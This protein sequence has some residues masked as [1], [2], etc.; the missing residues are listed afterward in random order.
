MSTHFVSTSGHSF[1]QSL[2]QKQTS[3]TLHCGEM[4]LSTK[5]EGNLCDRGLIPS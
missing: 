2:K 5:L 1:S 3:N 4:K